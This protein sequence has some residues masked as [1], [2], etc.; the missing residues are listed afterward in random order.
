MWQ[1]YSHVEVEDIVRLILSTKVIFY[2]KARLSSNEFLPRPLKD[3]LYVLC[4]NCVFPFQFKFT[5]QWLLY[6]K[7]FLRVVVLPINHLVC[8]SCVFNTLEDVASSARYGH[9]IIGLVFILGDFLNARLCPQ[10]L[11]RGSL[12]VIY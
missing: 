3:N 6:N 11:L 5:D 10:P 1:L 7:H 9:S 2:T 8:T 4:F 12:A